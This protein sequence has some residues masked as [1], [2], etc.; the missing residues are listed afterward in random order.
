MTNAQDRRDR[1][2][3]MM[4]ERESVTLS[5]LVEHFKVTD[6]SIRHDLT[7]LEEAGRLFRVRGG[8]VSPSARRAGS[9]FAAKARVN[10]PEKRRIARVA[11][12]LVRPGDVALFDSGSTV[13]E[14]AAQMP[15]AL[16]APHAMTVVSHSLPV[17]EE[18]GSWQQ[19]HVICLGGLLLP[20]YQASVGPLTLANLRELS[21]DIVFL[22]CDGLTLEGGL[23][24]PHM[25]IAEVGSAMAARARRVVAVA[26]STKLGTTGFTRIVGIDAVHVLVTDNGADKNLI[27]ELRDKDVEVIVV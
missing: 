24:T 27:A 10:L 4:E 22:G 2:A 6:T 21:A 15:A 23:T 5:E 7:V 8:A 13:A 19:P 12:E 17:V 14:V 11:A 9:T 16:R 3:R 25:L 26:D 20:D 1:I 18:A